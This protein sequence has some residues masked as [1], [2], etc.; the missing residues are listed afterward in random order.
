[1][2]YKIDLPFIAQEALERDDENFDFR[3]FLKNLD[4]GSNEL[5]ALVHEIND[6]VTAQIDCTQ[7]ANCC[8]VTHPVLSQKDAATFA[9]GLQVTAPIF[10]ESY[11]LPMEEEPG[12]FKFKAKPC[13]FLSD[14]LCTNYEAR[15]EVCRS[16]P[17]LHKKGFRSRLLS[18]IRN[19]G[20]CPIVYHVYE[21]LKRELWQ[22][23]NFAE[24]D[25]FADIW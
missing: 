14:D 2:T 6:E 7:C 25:F 8:K 19:Y 3:I 10:R 13:P 16:F 20:L 23:N 17:H 9:K 11:L 12:K 22:P 21:E 18:V 24:N 5:D 4:I 1:M 15:P